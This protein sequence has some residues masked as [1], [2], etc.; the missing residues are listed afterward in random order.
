M[1]RPTSKWQEKPLKDLPA[2]GLRRNDETHEIQKLVSKKK[3][4]VDTDDA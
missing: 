2:N 3:R 1:P 4:C